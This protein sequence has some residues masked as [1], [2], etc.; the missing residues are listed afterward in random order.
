MLS[1]IQ[2]FLEKNRKWLFGFLLIVIIIPFVFTIGNMPGLVK[3]KKAIKMHL[4]GYD[5]TDRSQVE[6]VV[7]KGAMSIAIR[8][9]SEEN[10]WMESAQGYA[11][12]R[13]LLLSVARDLKLPFPS[14]AVLQNFIKTRPL[15]CDENQE[16]QSSRYNAYL[17]NWKKTGNKTYTLRSLLEEDYLCDQVRSVMMQTQTSFEKEAAAF[18]KNVKTVYDLDYIVV[19]NDIQAPEKIHE[20]VLRTYY[21]EHKENY[22]IDRRADVTLL[23]FENK[24][25]LASLPK[26]STSD[27]QKYYEEHKNAF[28]E[29]DAIPEF[30][31]VQDRVKKAF[32]NEYLSRL[33]EENA[34]QFVITTYEKGW[35]I[36]SDDWKQALD[37]NDIRCIHSVQPYTQDDIP[38][39]KGLSKEM[40]LKAFDLTESHFLSDPMPVKNGVVLLALNKFLPSYLPD[41]EQVHEK[42][43]ADVKRDECQKAFQAKVQKLENILKAGKEGPHLQVRKM[44]G[45]S[46][47]NAFSKIKD[48]LSMS[49]MFE[50]LKNLQFVLLNVWS[51]AYEGKEDEA[52]LFCCRRKVIPEN[53]ENLDEY[54]TFVKSFLEHQNVMHTETL[55]REILEDTMNHQR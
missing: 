34:L 54:R 13:L 48:V 47:E 29:E 4:F 31:A 45:V 27:L 39:K 49:S 30:S 35:M 20:E 38:A 18:F 53:I 37:K 19:K 17:E 28:K 33:A 21:D 5:L 44:E 2:V 43:L 8:M 51:K 16:F 24:K 10:A 40:L 46:M 32:E 41:L 14:E 15:F 52:I 3:G 23:F 25:Y 42:V 50:F 7:Q 6:E 26:I 12:Y 22:R 55:L 9:G 11:F 1:R 36:G